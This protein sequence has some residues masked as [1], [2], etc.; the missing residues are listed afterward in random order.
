MPTVTNATLTLTETTT[1]KVTVKVT[2]DATFTAF[3]RQLFGLGLNYHSH[4]TV[5]G[6]DGSTV[7][8]PLVNTNFPHHHIGANEGL[9]VGTTD[10][11]R[12]IEEEFEFGRSL[13]QEDPVGDPDE[14]KCNIVIHSPLPLQFSEDVYTVTRVLA[15]F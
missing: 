14:L 5:H 6:V 15:T 8:P 10:Q 13:L 12:P 9:T 11:T 2:Y 3:E 1:Q 4:V 7:G